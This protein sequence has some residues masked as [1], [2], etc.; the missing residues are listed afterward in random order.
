MLEPVIYK[1]LYQGGHWDATALVQRVCNGEVALVVLG[2]PLGTGSPSDNAA[3]ADHQWPRP[4]LE[5]LRASVV[6]Q[7]VVAAGGGQRFVYV[8]DTSHGPCT[9]SLGGSQG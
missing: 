9:P 6:L 4:I 3:A 1:L 7:E 2:Y 8:P 5:A